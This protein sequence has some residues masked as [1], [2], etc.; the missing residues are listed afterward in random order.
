MTIA[1]LW[2]FFSSGVPADTS[3][4]ELQRYK[5]IFYSGFYAM[6][7][8]VQTLQDSELTPEQFDDELDALI[9]EAY[10]CINQFY[11]DSKQD[12]QNQTKH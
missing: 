7:R 8:E 10:E 5:V 11:D 3:E 12:K 2:E 4:T 9:L 6:L 1:E